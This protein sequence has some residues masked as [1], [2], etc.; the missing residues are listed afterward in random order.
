[1]RVRRRDTPEFSAPQHTVLATLPL[2]TVQKNKSSVLQAAIALM[3]AR[4]I[5]MVTSEEWQNLAKAVKAESGQKIEWRTHEE[6]LDA[7]D[8]ARSESRL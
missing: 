4:N 2:V 5:G 1:M 6:I 3:E 8:R 7:E